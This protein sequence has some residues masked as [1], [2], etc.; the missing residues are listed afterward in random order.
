MALRFALR[1]TSL[2]PRYAL[3]GKKRA[4][5][6]AP[7]LAG[8]PPVVANL[9][10][11][12]VFG[13]QALDFRHLGDTRN[14]VYRLGESW[15]HGSNVFSIITRIVPDWTGVP[16]NQW[17]MLRIGATYTG[18]SDAAGG[19]Y[20]EITDT[21]KLFCYGRYNIEA[22]GNIFNF[23]TPNP[24][25]FTTGVATDI[26]VTSDG[27]NF[28]VSQDGVQIHSGALA[29]A[30]K[31]FDNIVASLMQLG[32]YPCDMYFNEILIWDTC[33]A[34][35]YAAR[36]GFFAAND[37][38]GTLNVDPGQAFVQ[39][40]RGYTIDGLSKTG[41]LIVG[42]PPDVAD[43][44][45][46]T[47]FI[48]NTGST[49]TGSLIVPT[50][51]TGTASLVN[52]AQIKENLRYFF[53]D[54]NTTTANFDLSSGLDSGK[55]VKKIMS[56]HPGKL[57]MQASEYPYVSMFVDSKDIELK[58]M[59]GDQKRAKRH[60]MIR[61]KIVGGVWNNKMSNKKIDSAD[62]ECERLMENIEEIIRRQ[63]TLDGACLWHTPSGV[64]YHNKG[65]EEEAHLR[66]GILSL[67]IMVMT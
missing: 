39:L 66:I 41:A 2:V 31:T 38:D 9:A 54:A 42:T 48:D 27:V 3:G 43:V 11:G 60:H 17:R 65:M 62:D 5:F 1:G 56:K 44:R 34:H 57:P 30:T 64:T 50:V 13:G 29:D 20:M 45:F 53:N 22:G 4:H 46:G 7:A 61:L 51:Y 18:A 25:N 15:I 63:P 35:V 12:S 47:N 6:V 19:I 37:F 26:M 24:L 67:D 21:G 52:F 33:E 40:N 14:E 58:D 16:P 32:P 36:T 23:T 59:A 49:L 10:H 8:S 55:R 28:Y